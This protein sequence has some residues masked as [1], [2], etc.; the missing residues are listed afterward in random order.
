MIFSSRQRTLNPMLRLLIALTFLLPAAVAQT[1]QRTAVDLLNEGMDAFKAARYQEAVELFKRAL[2]LDPTETTHLYLATAYSS[3]VVPN[4]D[5]GEN[6]KTANRA[7]EQFDIVLRSHPDHLV[8]LLQEASIYRYTKRP[9]EALALY[10]S[11]KIVDPK[12]P[13]TPYAIGVIDWQEAYR[14]TMALLASEGLVD[15][16]DGNIA[17]SPALCAKFISQNG[18]LLDDALTNLVQAV[19]LNPDYEEALTYISLVYRRKAD[20]HSKDVTAITSDLE[21][22]D[23]WAKKSFEARQRIE[24]KRKGKN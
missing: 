17:K 6:L 20:L 13:E 8:A 15:K 1:P 18:S 2:A 4:L 9:D 22:A 16:S 7:I 19:D 24:A 3:Q 10:R 11:A 5:T 21:Q 23:S 12:N 14:N